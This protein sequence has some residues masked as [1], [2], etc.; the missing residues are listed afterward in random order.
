MIIICRKPYQQSFTMEYFATK[1]N[2]PY[3]P[4]N[5]RM[6]FVAE[7]KKGFIATNDGREL[8]KF[9]SLEDQIYTFSEFLHRFLKKCES[10]KKFANKYNSLLNRTKKWKKL[11]LL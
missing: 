7:F 8:D 11:E 3:I 6:M 9:C 1:Y 5:R 2:Q 4:T 10:C